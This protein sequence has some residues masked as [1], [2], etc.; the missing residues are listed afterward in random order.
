PEA[1]GRS[2]SDLPLVAPAR[3]EIERLA[4][5]YPQI[6]DGLPLSPLPEG[7]LFPALSD[8][9]A[10]DAYN[11]PPALGLEGALEIAGLE[12]AVDALLLRHASLRACFWHAGLSRP[13]Q[14]IVPT[15][16]PRWRRLDLSLLDEAS[17]AQRLA[18]ELGQDRG[19]RFDLSCA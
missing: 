18:S 3:G 15:V 9:Q 4:R 6:E 17:G 14:V 5:P 1:G 12:A 19:E 11:A 8:A 2:P 13:V 16:K 7:L 10:P